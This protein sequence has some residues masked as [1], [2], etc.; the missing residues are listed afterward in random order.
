VL[1]LTG[2]LSKSI[3]A[4]IFEL[5]VT[6]ADMDI[7]VGTYELPVKVHNAITEYADYIYVATV[8]IKI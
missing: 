1:A 5:R 7:A 3:D 4:T 8:K 6:G 2:A